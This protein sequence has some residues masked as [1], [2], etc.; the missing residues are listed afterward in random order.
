MPIQH[1]ETGNFNKNVAGLGKQL[2]ASTPKLNP[3]RI[4][5]QWHPSMVKDN[6]DFWMTF[7]DLSG[8]YHL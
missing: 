5:V 3:L 4:S 7:G 1:A 8:I 6:G 2:H